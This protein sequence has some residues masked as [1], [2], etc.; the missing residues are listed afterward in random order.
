MKKRSIA[1]IMHFRQRQG[2]CVQLALIAESTLV[3][4][5]SREVRIKSRVNK[6]RV[7]NLVLTMKKFN[8]KI[9]N[10]GNI[11]QVSSVLAWRVYLLKKRI[12][13]S[14]H[15]CLKSRVGTMLVSTYLKK[16]RLTFVKMV[17]KQVPYLHS[18]LLSLTIFAV[19]KRKGNI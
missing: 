1:T 10:G 12:R 15:K 16:F 11:C 6:M 5:D 19:D 18:K 9:Q 14:Q 13:Q 17:G 8:L 7:L 4:G 2:Q 3:P